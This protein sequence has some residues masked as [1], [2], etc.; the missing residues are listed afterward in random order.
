MRIWGS[1]SSKWICFMSSVKSAS[2]CPLSAFLGAFGSSE[3]RDSDINNTPL[4]QEALSRCLSDPA[5]ADWWRPWSAELLA[6]HLNA[7]NVHFTNSTQQSRLHITFYTWEP[8][9][10]NRKQT[11]RTDEIS[12][13]QHPCSKEGPLHSNGSNAI[14]MFTNCPNKIFSGVQEVMKGCRAHIARHFSNHPLCLHNS[15]AIWTRER[16]WENK[17]G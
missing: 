1:L 17:L 14:L 2:L 5:L 4:C 10:E 9:T 11:P 7:A 6:F 3:F 15:A 16:S 12:S 13:K 8:E